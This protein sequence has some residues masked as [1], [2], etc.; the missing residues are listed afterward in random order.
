MERIHIKSDTR[1]AGVSLLRLG[2]VGSD[3]GGLLAGTDV[4]DSGL[5]G[6]S[7]K[8]IRL[9]ALFCLLLDMKYFTKEEMNPPIDIMM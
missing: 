6:L 5:V 4:E 8:C 3:G 7:S 2:V 1:Y 9:R